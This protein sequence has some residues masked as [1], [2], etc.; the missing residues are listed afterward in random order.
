MARHSHGGHESKQALTVTLVLFILLSLILGVL[1]YLGYAE[2]GK[3]E[4]EAKKAKAEKTAMSKQRNEQK[5][6]AILARIVEGR[7]EKDDE[8]E[9]VDLKA[10]HPEAYKSE[11]ERYKKEVRWNVHQDKPEKDGTYKATIEKLRT[12]YAAELK[13]AQTLQTQLDDLKAENDKLVKMK[14]EGKATSDKNYEELK[15]KTEAALAKYQAEHTAQ[16][17][18]LRKNME[19]VQKYVDAIDGTGGYKSQ[20]A[21]LRATLDKQRKKFNDDKKRIEEKLPV[22]DILAYD[23]PKGKV[24]QVDRTGTMAT[25]S[26]GKA[27]NVQP[28][29]TFSIYAPNTSHVNSERRGTLEV[30]DVLSDHQSRCRI[31]ETTYPTRLPIQIDDNIYNPAWQPGQ[32]QH[33]AVVGKID[34]TGMGRDDTVEFVRT[35]REQGTVVDLYIDP[36]TNKRIITDKGMTTKTYYLIVGDKPKMETKGNMKSID[37]K[38][39]E[40]FK[41][42]ELMAEVE[43]EA[44]KLGVQAVSSQ[45]F[46]RLSGYRMPK[47]GSPDGGTVYSLRP[48]SGVP[49]DDQKNLPKQ[50]SKPGEK[51]D[52]KGKMDPKMMMPK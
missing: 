46:L 21:S 35:L 16:L 39:T 52:E 29:L 5:M 51:M 9:L 33:V 27:D 24:V 44:E 38:L 26:V 45:R 4:E 28:K 19:E 25:I 12:E 20:V 31:T 15:A 50:M 34:L 47:I 37:P 18:E 40:A 11:V 17:I 14:D 3:Q 1:T 41:I 8:T 6:R 32:A 2:A 42:V 13:K 7:P 36:R 49:F 22:P 10:Q 43:K 23:R 48:G 30:V